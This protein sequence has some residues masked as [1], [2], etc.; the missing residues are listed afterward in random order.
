MS[1]KSAGRVSSGT[2]T[3]VQET[4]ERLGYRPN[5]LAQVLRTGNAHL[6]ALAV[7]NVT[8]PFFGA[9]L[10]AAEL[11]AR[12]HGYA[13][14]LIDTTSDPFWA[15][16]ILE[17]L[18]SRLLAGC[19]VYAGDDMPSS[20]LA[21]RTDRVLFVEAEDAGRAALDIDIEQGVRAVVKHLTALGHQRIGYFAADYPKA[22]YRRR[23]TTFSEELAAAG[24]PFQPHWRAEATFDV[25]TA[26]SVGCA[27][28]E[29]AEV[30]AVFCDDDLLAGALYRACRQLGLRI[31]EDLSVIGF[32]DIEL[33][34]MLSPELTTLAIPADNIGRNAVELLLQ[35]LEPDEQE[36]QRPLVTKLEL[37]VRGS[38]AVARKGLQEHET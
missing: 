11:A 12:E 8:H 30:T 32:D 19:I 25:D 31:P 3:L 1:G 38:S 5:V 6:I 29:R 14:T 15:D 17:L 20:L 34:R 24:L 13:M 23:F 9:V 2:L 33:A 16:R 18:A 36:V 37:K 27:L 4:A 22:T 21:L 7:P 28:L 10:V 26:T 35:Q